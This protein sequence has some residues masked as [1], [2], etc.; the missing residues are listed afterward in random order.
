MTRSLP[1]RPDL[2]HLRHE[3]KT[4]LRAARSGA[5]DATQRLAAVPR[6]VALSLEQRRDTARLADAQHALAREYGF[7]SWPRL[8]LEVEARQ[9]LALHATRFLKALRD[10]DDGR[11]ARI[12]AQ[13][14]GIA[15]IDACVAAAL[16]DEPA[17]IAAVAADPRCATRDS[18]APGWKPL[19]YCC[20]GTALAP[21]DALQPGRVRIVEHAL[22]NGA[23]ANAGVR[24]ATGDDA[25]P[26]LSAL[27]FAVQSGA[28]GMVRVL[29]AHGAKPNDGE[30]VFHGAQHDRRDCLDALLAH[31][32]DLDATQA[33]YHNTPLYFLMGFAE[34]H[35][36]TE[37][38]DRG[39]EWLLAHGANPDAPSG[40]ARE[41]ALHAAARHGRGPAMIDRLLASGARIDAARADGVTPLGLA[42]R[43]GCAGTAALLRAR[44][45]RARADGA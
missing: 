2:D 42:L 29:L 9:P 16:G 6:L 24:W 21:D 12:A 41:T 44:G 7:E 25:S 11:A 32:A 13:H 17:F 14:P 1:E 22:A 39:V 10:G 15:R 26:V 5:L 38:S 40:A 20:V 35:V 3:A 31:G 23:D 8:K 30:S 36:G 37:R 19:F 27:Y 18:G 34:G 4:L 28:L 43:E 33:P 45:G